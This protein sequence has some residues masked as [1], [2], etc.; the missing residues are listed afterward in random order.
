MA[1][2]AAAQGQLSQVDS[3]QDYAGF[4]A[5]VLPAYG[6]GAA[7]TCQLINLSENG[8]F[9]VVEGDRTAILRVHR[10]GYHAPVAIESELAWIDALRADV[11]VPTP[12]PIPAAD[13]RRV[14]SASHAGRS[15]SA[16]LFEPLPGREPPAED[17]SARFE[18][19]GQITARMHEHTMGWQRPAWFSRFAW[20]WDCT[21]GAT[22]R[23]GR[24]QDGPGVGAAELA[25]LSRAADLLGRRLAAF[26]TGPDRFGLVHADLRLANLLVDGDQVAVIDFD[27]CGDSWHLYDLGAAVSF[28][29]DDP[30][31]PAWCDAWV[32]GYRS[33][34]ALSGADE[35]E[36]P[37]FV[38]L[39]R[40]ML[41]AWIGS[42]STTD[43][44]QEMG[45]AYTA[46]SCDLAEQYLS[47]MSRPNP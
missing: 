43:L 28:L 19:L 39:R 42:H 45:P 24:W 22:P 38:W 15:R 4:A 37:S 29:E 41:V 11:G 34:R 36:I 1:E 2:I 18:L 7:A 3:P 20:D 6:F 21:L 44:A 16:V 14:V 13:G 46:A 10:E 47:A 40:L 9:R 35:A 23:W 31:V 17:F 25:V 30:R 26:G 12:V 5:E 27:D 33:V 8:T 32:T